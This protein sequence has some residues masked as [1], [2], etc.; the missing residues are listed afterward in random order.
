MRFND[1]ASISKMQYRPS[2]IQNNISGK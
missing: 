1:I 2:T